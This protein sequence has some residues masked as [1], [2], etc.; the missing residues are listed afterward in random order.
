MSV[1]ESIE[2]LWE[3]VYSGRHLVVM[4]RRREWMAARLNEE[5]GFAELVR[6]LAQDVVQRGGTRGAAQLA[7]EV[8]FVAAQLAHEADAERVVLARPEEGSA[9]VDRLD[10]AHQRARAL[11]APSAAWQ[12]VLADGIQ[13][14]VA[15]T[16]HAMRERFRTVVRTAEG[17]IDRSDPETG[18]PE[19]ETWLRRQVTSVA[20]EVNDLLM[21]RTTELSDASPTSS[22]A[23]CRAGSLPQLDDPMAALGRVSVSTEFTSRRIGPANLALTVAR[24]SSGGVIMVGM[25]AGLLGLAVAAPISIAVGALLGRKAL[26][27][28]RTRQLGE[29]RRQAKATVRSFVD[30]SSFLVTKD[31]KDDLR[32]IQRHLRDQFTAHARLLQRSTADA[33]EVAERALADARRRP[34]G[35]GAGGGGGAARL[36]RAAP[37]GR[38]HG[39]SRR[40]PGQGGVSG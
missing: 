16:D 30:E 38:G 20:V 17:I 4:R 21:S 37:P 28:E 35:A 7:H 33:L 10:E 5:S 40:R 9:V 19:F 1:W 27:D 34:P 25:A 2:A 3:F 29:R 39:R 14:L 18:W 31:T 15:E 11:S 8:D 36:G 32:R 6:F 23:S 24:G 12:Q 22:T 13:D 26:K